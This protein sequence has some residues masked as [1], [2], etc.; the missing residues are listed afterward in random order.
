MAPVLILSTAGNVIVAMALAKL[1]AR[2]NS[3]IAIKELNTKIVSVPNPYYDLLLLD[4][5]PSIDVKKA[6]KEDVQA[7]QPIKILVD[8]AP[9]VGTNG[10]RFRVMTLSGLSHEIHDDASLTVNDIPT[11]LRNAFDNTLLE[12]QNEITLT[13]DGWSQIKAE[14]KAGV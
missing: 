11:P 13:G 1:I 8:A 14:L 9:R 7:D 10:K 4:T 6:V 5:N 12:M 3:M 2:S